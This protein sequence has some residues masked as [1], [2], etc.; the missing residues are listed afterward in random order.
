[1][2]IITYGWIRS[3]RYRYL[4]PRR[5]VSQIQ[6]A[7][8][9]T[10]G[11]SGTLSGSGLSSQVTV[12]FSSTAVLTDAQPVGKGIAYPL[13]PVRWNQ[14]F[15]RLDRPSGW[16][17]TT[18]AI[19]GTSSF[20]FVADGALVAAGAMDGAAT[21]AVGS[22]VDLTARGPVTAS[23]SLS[24][25]SSAVLNQDLAAAITIDISPT[26]AFLRGRGALAGET[27]FQFIASAPLGAARG[28][29]MPV[30]PGFQVYGR[31]RATYLSA[32]D[33]AARFVLVGQ[34][35]V[36][37]G[38]SAVLTTANEGAIVGASLTAFSAVG[39]PRARGQLAGLTSFAF[40]G[41][42][43]VINGAAS[44]IQGTAT[45]TIGSLPTISGVAGLVG[46]GPIA[47]SSNARLTSGAISGSSTIAVSSA[48]AIG[49]KALITGTAQV[50]F[51]SSAA[52][53]T[54]A[55]DLSANVVAVEFGANA[56]ISTNQQRI[57]GAAVISFASAV[58]NTPQ[59]GVR[60]RSK[61]NTKT[62]RRKFV[63]RPQRKKVMV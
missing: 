59:S 14:G 55:L 33:F 47:I 50:A 35:T 57:S 56:S 29:A 20:A 3:N 17:F 62:H 16:Q 30:R 24:F 39:I 60:A 36:E 40:S 18:S 23:A 10:L 34:S 46:V 15:V 21:V 22:S 48:A 9:V 25:T 54:I 31:S 61:K 32:S 58:A 44:Q 45:V 26:A 1:M 27:S 41:A 49:I 42:G 13:H 63:T 51:S 2:E 11:A 8:T 53:S 5:L 4:A 52:G 37:F 43:T 7:A 19:I 6:G 12:A 38:S 28:L